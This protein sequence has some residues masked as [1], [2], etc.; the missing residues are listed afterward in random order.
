M[1][2]L[3]AVECL[4]EDGNRTP[5]LLVLTSAVAILLA[6]TISKTKVNNKEHKNATST[7]TSYPLPPEGITSLSE[8]L[9]C[10]KA[11]KQI[12]T[13]EKYGN[14]FMMKSPLPGII[15][16]QIVVT[17]PSVVKELTIR[18]MNQYHDPCN[19]TTRTDQF[20]KLVQ[21]VVGKGVTGVKGHEWRWRK[22]ALLKAFH[23][24]A[25]M[26]PKLGLLDVVLEEGRQLCLALDIAALDQGAVEVDVLTTKAAVGVVLFFL[27]GR[28]LEF[29]TEEVRESAELLMECLGA[30]LFNP[31]YNVQKYFPGT[32]ASKLEQGKLRAHEIIDSVV[33]PEIKRLLDEHAGKVP[34]HPGRKPGSVIATLLEQEPRFVEGGVDS[35]IAEARVFVQA[36]FETTAHSLA[37]ALGMLAERKDLAESLAREG[38]RILGDT[39]TATDTDTSK[40]NDFMYSSNVVE[41][42]MRDAPI[43]KNFFLESVRL[44]PL[45]PSLGGECRQD[46]DVKTSDGISYRFPK[47]AS[48]IF[49]NVPLQR[50]V[51]NPEEIR[52]ERWDVPMSQQPFLHT[53]QNG[54]HACPGKPLSLLEGQVFLMLIATHFEFDFATG[55]KVEF[56]DNLLLR[57]KDGM[58]LIVKRRR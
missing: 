32:K 26:D 24:S 29:D 12:E 31:F 9:K 11:D 53:F 30:M 5:V 13:V 38:K 40:A 41:Q 7:S 3:D 52:P 25:M 37:F 18:Q 54:A 58:P 34:M 19:F 47:G 46:I 22:V 20:C 51:E 44:Y 35:M 16:L 28:K 36:G 39:A 50:H 6:V 49:L 8:F 1:T 56:E 27:F 14:V 21:N 42:G 55:N 4:L 15:P 10:I 33:A 23:K 43:Y 17:D 45:A 48:L 2:F 57:P